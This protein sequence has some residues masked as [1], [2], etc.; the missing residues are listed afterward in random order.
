MH[1]RHSKKTK[2][3]HQGALLVYVKGKHSRDQP[4]PRLI[5]LE[6][7]SQAL[8]QGPSTFGLKFL[9]KKLLKD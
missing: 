8:E 3:R 4:K 9:S 7:L 1:S 6:D 2:A 5:F